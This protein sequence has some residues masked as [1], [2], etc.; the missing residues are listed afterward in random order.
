MW[1]VYRPPGA[2]LHGLSRRS[3]RATGWDHV[4]IRVR[5]A[6]HPVEIQRFAA[7]QDSAE[8]HLTA[9]RGDKGADDRN[10]ESLTPEQMEDL[11]AGRPDTSHW[12]DCPIRIGPASGT[13]RLHVEYAL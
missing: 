11:I 2:D 1:A 5:V 9:E 8:L 7:G 10:E 13:P 6:R 4:A 3:Q 12:P